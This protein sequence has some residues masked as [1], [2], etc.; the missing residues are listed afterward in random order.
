[1]LNQSKTINETFKEIMSV[2]DERDNR[3]GYLERLLLDKDVIIKELENRN[4]QLMYA[5]EDEINNTEELEN[6]IKK[7]EY[8][9]TQLRYALEDEI[10]NTEELEELLHEKDDL[11]DR[12]SEDLSYSNSVII[13]LRIK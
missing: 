6:T 3:I 13:E 8:R 2:I 4:T 7:L 5:L 11:I 9:E 12:L 1:M 10:N